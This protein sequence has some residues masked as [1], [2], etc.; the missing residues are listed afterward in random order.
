MQP[1]RTKRQRTQQKPGGKMFGTPQSTP[2]VSILAEVTAERAGYDF[3]SIADA[4]P[5]CSCSTNSDLCRTADGEPDIW[6]YESGTGSFAWSAWSFSGPSLCMSSS[7]TLQH[8]LILF[9]Y[10]ATSLSPSIS[11]PPSTLAQTSAKHRPLNFLPAR[12]ARFAASTSDPRSS[13][14]F[15]LSAPEHKRACYQS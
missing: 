12:A 9:S 10:H 3:A 4:T 14:Q 8:C 2:M 1:V 6:W 11:P 5:P 13:R 7:S 15:V